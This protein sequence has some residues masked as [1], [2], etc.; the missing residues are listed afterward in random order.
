M[1]DSLALA[2]PLVGNRLLFHG[3]LRDV[4]RLAVREFRNSTTF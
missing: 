4:C 2:I 1:C 3:G